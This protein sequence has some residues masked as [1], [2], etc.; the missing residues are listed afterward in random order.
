M[1]NSIA[2]RIADKLIEYNTINSDDRDIYEFGINQIFTTFLNLITVLIIGTLMQ[3]KN[4]YSSS[5]H[6]YH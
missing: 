6:L 2:V 4:Q 5:L 1:F 3:L